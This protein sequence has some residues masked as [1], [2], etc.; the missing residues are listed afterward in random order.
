MEAKKCLCF[1]FKCCSECLLS[2]QLT[3]L[4]SSAIAWAYCFEKYKWDAY[5][6]NQ[7]NEIF[8]KTDQF[9][10]ILA[11]Y[12]KILASTTTRGTQNIAQ[13]VV[14]LCGHQISPMITV[15]LIS[16]IYLRWET[17]LTVILGHLLSTFQC[18]LT[19]HMD[20]VQ[21]VCAICNSPLVWRFTP[22]DADTVLEDLGDMRAN[23]SRKMWDKETVDLLSSAALS[24][25]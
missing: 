20:L 13:C 25:P 1:I 21:L 4:Q 7:S 9:C 22:T 14:C 3:F 2:S 15:V 23:L 17:I 8:C 11:M 19:G 5:F 18:I 10:D 6:S 24:Y 16:F 12:L